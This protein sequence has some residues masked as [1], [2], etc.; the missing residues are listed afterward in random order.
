MTAAKVPSLVGVARKLAAAMAPGL[1]RRISFYRN[2]GRLQRIARRLVQ[3]HGAIVLNGPFQG[4]KYVAG[5]VGSV[6]GPK[7]VGSYEAELHPAIEQIVVR[8]Y[9]TVVDIGCAE[10]YYA[11]GLLRRMPQARAIAYDLNPEGRR[12]CRKM[13]ELNGV[14]ARLDIRAGCTIGELRGLPLAGAFILCDCESAELDLLD[15]ERV[16][17]LKHC[18]LLVELHD[19]IVPHTT[20]TITRRFA[21]THHVQIIYARR[22]ISADY[23]QLSFLSRKDREMAVQEFRPDGMSWAVLSPRTNSGAN[24]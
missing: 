12:L 9:P 19:F 4:M 11:V 13:A 14:A 3:R 6:Y 2:E 24:P 15:P 17:S 23:P 8:N 5:S 1:Y 18:D 16:P 7:L 10:G 22:K 20:E 21:L